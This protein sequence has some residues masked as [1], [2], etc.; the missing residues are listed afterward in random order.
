METINLKEMTK[1]QLTTLLQKKIF[2][3]G[4]NGL[5]QN[6]IMKVINEVEKELARRKEANISQA[7]TQKEENKQDGNLTQSVQEDSNEQ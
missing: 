3:L 2:Q 7:N 1:E 5:Q 6:D 4:M